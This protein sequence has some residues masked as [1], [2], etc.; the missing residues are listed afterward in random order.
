M[1]IFVHSWKMP[2]TH[3]FGTKKNGLTFSVVPPTD[4]EW[5][6][7]RT[8][9]DDS[10]HS[11]IAKPQSRVAINPN[12]FLLKQIPLR[13]KAHIQHTESPSNFKTIPENGFMGWRIESKKHKTGL[14][15]V[16][17]ESARTVIATASDRLGRT[18]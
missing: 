12:L 11:C 18:R 1:C 4:P 16:R 15:L 13:W 3:K 5:S 8:N 9:T 6:I 17:S 10:I 2:R 7:V 14:F